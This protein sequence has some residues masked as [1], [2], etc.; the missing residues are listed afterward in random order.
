MVNKHSGPWISRSAG[1]DVA[2]VLL[3]VL[4]I[5]GCALL[6]ELDAS[7]PY[8]KVPKGSVIELHE[9][10]EIPPEYTRVWI[11]QG[12][13]R[14]PRFNAFA[15]SCGVEVAQVDQ[16]APQFVEPGRFRVVRTQYLREEIV[17]TRPV[18]LASSAPMRLAGN[19]EQDVSDSL[20][21]EGYHLWVENPDQP[22]VRRFTCRGVYDFPANA[23]PPSI[24]DIRAVLGP[25]ATLWLPEDLEASE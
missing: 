19:L 15:P 13:V 11:Q 12:E 17:Q 24:R 9:R 6:P 4:L 21:H 10:I 23:K 18:T 25:V 20:Y 8:Y 14:G 3:T 1:I 16:S 5:G 2:F 7:S 22:T